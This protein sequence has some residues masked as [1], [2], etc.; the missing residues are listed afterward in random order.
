M[1]LPLFHCFHPHGPLYQLELDVHDPLPGIRHFQSHWLVEVSL[2]VDHL[3]FETIGIAGL[4]Q[5][6]LGFVEIIFIGPEFLGRPRYRWRQGRGEGID[7][8]S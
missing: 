4:R 7:H 8:A 2:V 1:V 6:L 5:E 3:Q